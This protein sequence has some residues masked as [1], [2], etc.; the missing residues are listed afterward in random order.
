MGPMLQTALETELQLQSAQ[1]IMEQNHGYLDQLSTIQ[2]PK[3]CS[4][5]AVFP[6]VQHCETDGAAV[7]SHYN[8]ILTYIYPCTYNCAVSS[9]C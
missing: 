7:S 8:Y 5:Y 9:D 1:K 4:L 3:D 6:N 2:I